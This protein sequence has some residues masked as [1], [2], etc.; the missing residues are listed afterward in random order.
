MTRLNL[1][2]LF[3]VSAMVVTYALESR[4]KLFV[5]A[6]GAACLLGSVYGFHAGSVAFRNGRDCLVV[7]A[8]RRWF[9][10]TRGAR[11]N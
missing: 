6:F 1:F 5:L 7:I 4:H 3:A 9:G 8:V 10:I 11:Q 2:G